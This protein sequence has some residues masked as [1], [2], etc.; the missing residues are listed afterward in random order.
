MITD[1]Q[2]EQARTAADAR[3]AR[4]EQRGDDRTW[5]P[6]GLSGREIHRIGILGEYAFVN[7]FGGE[8]DL[9]FRPAGDD[10]GDIRISGFVVDVK[11]STYTGPH[12]YLRVPVARIHTAVIYVAALYDAEADDV[13]LIRWEWG[14][15]LV[16]RNE[17]RC[18]P[19]HDNPNYVQPYRACRRL[20]DLKQ[21]LTAPKAGV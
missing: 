7:E 13:A 10:G 5:T 18:F 6:N 11:T 4:H 20:D 1:A 14:H 19:P 9:Q 17:V 21:L 15:S 2:R 3:E 12:Q 8:V 16:A